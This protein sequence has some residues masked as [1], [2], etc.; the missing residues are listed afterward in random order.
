MNSS[1]ETLL[2]EEKE[3][4]KRLRFPI[5]LESDHETS[6]PGKPVF[7]RNSTTESRLTNSPVETLSDDDASDLILLKDLKIQ[8]LTDFKNQPEHPLQER[9][10]FKEEIPKQTKS[11]VEKAEI[12]LIDLDSGYNITVPNPTPPLI[13][14]D[15]HEEVDTSNQEIPNYQKNPE[16]KLTQTNAEPDTMADMES[17]A[18]ELTPIKIRTKLT[19]TAKKKASSPMKSPPPK[20]T[21]RYTFSPQ[22]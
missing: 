12:P 1:R 5:G 8:N 10:D 2:R 15:S 18:K 7:S 16:M 14:L 17:Q 6:P 11:K 13:I 21:A 9:T 20:K 4:R 22:H 19:G 3:Q